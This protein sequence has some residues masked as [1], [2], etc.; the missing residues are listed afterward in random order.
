M[1]VATL[2]SKLYPLLD[3]PVANSSTILSLLRRG[4]GLAE[5]EVA[6]SL[7]SKRTEPMVRQMLADPDPVVRRRAVRWVQLTFAYS[8]AVRI[9]RN[10]AKDRS[11]MVRSAAFRAARALRVTDV[12]LPARRLAKVPATTQ[13]E[14]INPFTRE[15]MVIPAR[16][17]SVR[18]IRG[19]A[20]AG[21]HFGLF[22]A[23][24]P[25]RR[26]APPL[27]ALKGRQDV[28]ELLGVS[29]QEV[30]RLLRPGSGPGT[31]YVAF[32]IPK[33]SGGVR[34]LHAPKHVLKRLQ[35]KIA[36]EL[37]DPIEP[38]AAAHGFVRGRSTVTNAQPHVNARLLVKMDIADF[39]PTVHYGRVVGL[40][41]HHGAGK[42]AA[43]LLAAITTYR[44]KLPDG[45]VSWPSVLPQGAPTSPVLSNLV[46]RRL[47]ARLT[48]LAARLGAT[49]TRYADDLTFSFQGDPEQGL[50]RFFWWVNQILH[51]EGFIE[52]IGKRRVHRPSGQMRVT[53]L[54]TNQGLSVPR[55]ER[56]RFRAILHACEQ[57]GVSS[58]TTGHSEPR[59]YLLG[60]AAYVEM[61]QP[62]VG[63]K[64]R[65]QVKRL[66][67]KS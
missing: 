3:D 1:D 2:I 45:R 43:K 17:P 35:R 42:E 47:D 11:R 41:E 53:G 12:A 5:Y 25:S 15:R 24:P 8:P 13:R 65:A 10:A 34:T 46:C 39:F 56:R 62:E 18:E 55:E 48:A 9:V 16:S 50:G 37:L 29:E 7:V 44:P 67:A 59:A 51:Q 30:T 60:F 36:T 63:K 57:R 61:V 33:A 28:L 52:N 27:A 40:L 32:E 6:R 49:Y 22:R 66:L 23:R 26:P 21:W 31:S 58:E 14:G 64:L 4:G 38:H 20:P 19:Y 54:V